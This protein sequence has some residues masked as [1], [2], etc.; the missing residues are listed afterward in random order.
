MNND[1]KVCIVT[2]GSSG[3]GAAIVA[4]FCE[5]GYQVF[6]LD[7]KA[8]ESQT[9]AHH[10]NCDVSDFTAVKAAIDGIISHTEK[11]DVLISNAG[12]HLSANIENTEEDVFDKLMDLNVKGAFAATQAVLPAMK[13]QGGAIIYIASDQALIAKHNSFAY[14]LSKHALA[15]MAKTTALDYAQFN[16][17]ANALCPGTIETPLYHQAIDAYCQ[18]SGADKNAVHAEEAALQPLGRLGQ[19][20]E[21]ADFALFLASDKASFITGSLQ[22]IDGGYSCQ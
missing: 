20:E 6:N 8:N 15:S 2:G 4:R 9:T 21:I 7:I 17:R 18:R 14:N 11:V 13:Q 19:P 3:I 12:R 22:A 16:I 10:I 5:N 1:A